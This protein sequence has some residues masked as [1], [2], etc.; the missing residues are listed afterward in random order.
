MC[1]LVSPGINCETEMDECESAPCQNGATCHD[2]VAMYSC[3]CPPGFEGIDCELDVDE[4]V[5]QP[6]QNGAACRDLVNR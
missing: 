4:C 6:C 1:D 2:L 5:S 3:E